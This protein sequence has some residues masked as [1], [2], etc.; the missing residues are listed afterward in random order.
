MGWKSQMRELRRR[1]LEISEFTPP[2]AEISEL[3][4][5]ESG[6]K[7]GTPRFTSVPIGSTT[8]HMVQNDVRLLALQDGKNGFVHFCE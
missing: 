3:N 8:Q 1:S 4:L 6:N 2:P 7:H 5:V